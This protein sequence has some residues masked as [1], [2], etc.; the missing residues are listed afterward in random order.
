[1]VEADDLIAAD[2]EARLPDGGT[3]GTLGLGGDI[4]RHHHNDPIAST[5]AP[6]TSAASLFARAWSTGSRLAIF[7]GHRN[8]RGLARLGACGAAAADVRGG[9]WSAS[10]DQPLDQ[11]A[12]SDALELRL[13][14]DEAER[15]HARLGVDL[16]QIDA[17]FAQLIVPAEVGARRALAAEQLMRPRRHVHHRA[18]DLVRDFGGADVLRQAVG[19]F[20]VIIVEAGLG[21]QFG[22]RK[23]IAAHHRDGQLAPLDEGLGEK[24]V[25]M[26]PRALDVAADRVAGNCRRR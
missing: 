1:M 22:H 11:L 21:L 20:G 26:L 12:V 6:K 4:Q 10:V 17:R 13:L 3:G 18:C 9:H 19:I 25:E 15:G 14:G 5:N 8:L 2:L 7:F 23:R 24:L 16:E